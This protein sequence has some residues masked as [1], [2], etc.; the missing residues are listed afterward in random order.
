MIN[1]DQLVRQN[2]RNLEPYT[3]ARD[4][5]TGSEGVFLDANENPF[6]T[7]NRYPDPYQK[8]LKR[9][10]SDL[11][12]FPADQIFIGNGSDE[13]I[14]LAFRVFCEPGKDK[15][16]TFTPTY[17]M[18]SVS[19]A[20]NNVELI[21]LPLD[22]DFQP[23]IELLEDIADQPIRLIFLCS[24][25][26]PTA[27][28]YLAKSIDEIIR[29]FTGIVVLDEAYIDFSEKESW[30]RRLNDYPNLIV[31][32]TFSKAW[33]LAAARLGVAYASKGIIDFFNKV[34]PP[35][36]ISKPNQEAAGAAL[37]NNAEVQ[38]NIRRI[39]AQRDWL[40][41]NLEKLEIVKKIYPSDANFLLVEVDD[42]NRTYEYLVDKKVIVR[43]RNG[44]VRNCLRITVGSAEEN[45]KLL[46][47]LK[48]IDS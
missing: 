18:Y 29:S 36:N 13:I 42:A 2:I 37:L 25:N 31:M 26:N 41:N 11:K 12:E 30:L 6:G 15:A 48:D 17:G 8:E 45:Q 4:E 19:A 20:I 43:N 16:A 38:Q 7:L 27:N 28:S 10:L 9:R 21:E 44:L 23:N 5:Y 3:S 14:D 34:K 33:G 22:N 39:L 24:P 46:A 1:L 35:Y 40:A 32:Q 47:A